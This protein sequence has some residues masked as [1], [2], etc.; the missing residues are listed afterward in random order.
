MIKIFEDVPGI[1][2]MSERKEE[3]E[4]VVQYFM[5]VSPKT[6]RISNTIHKR[7]KLESF[8]NPTDQL[9][10]ELEEIRRCKEGYGGMSPKMYFYFNYVSML[11]ITE[12]KIFPQY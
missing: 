10:W 9:M 11:N 7:V 12:G 6:S 3:L 8:K 5:A 2:P 1:I 4:K